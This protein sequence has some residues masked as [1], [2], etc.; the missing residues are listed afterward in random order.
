MDQEPDK[1]PYVHHTMWLDTKLLDNEGPP[2]EH[3]RYATYLYTWK[4]HHPNWK[5][6]F[7]N[8]RRVQKLWQDP[9][10]AKWL[11]TYQ[12][13]RH[14]IERCDFSRYAILYIYGGLYTD[15]DL[16]CLSSHEPLLQG[17]DLVTVREPQSHVLF[18][19]LAPIAN[20]YL[21]A[22]P[23][24]PFLARL[25][26]NVGDRYNANEGPVYNT[27]PYILT[28]TLHEMNI[29]DYLDPN[30]LF[31]LGSFGEI[32]PSP[33]EK[34]YAV[35][36]WRDG[37]GWNSSTQTLTWLAPLLLVTVI[38]TVLIIVFLLRR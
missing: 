1:M 27:G 24:H 18:D 16:I 2:P 3:L 5:H 22:S 12:K 15:L 8:R 20:G 17:R 35:G 36:V 31:P 21:A 38:V 34:N 30:T 19:G 9:R 33:G 7:W 4:Y 13:L 29:S 11:P 6:M 25:M 28:K 10:L 32:T 14:H 37:S 23:G 26:N